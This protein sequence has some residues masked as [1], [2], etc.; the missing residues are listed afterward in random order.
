[1]SPAQEIYQ[2]VQGGAAAQ[3]TTMPDIPLPANILP[4]QIR[5]CFHLGQF[6]LALVLQPS[7]NIWL[8]LPA[9][10]VPS[11]QGLLLT[12]EGA[13]SWTPFLQIQ[14][15]APTDK[16]NPYYLWTDQ[17][18]LYLTIVDQGGAG[19]G[20]GVMKLLALAPEGTWSLVGCYYFGTYSDPEQDG[21]YFQFSQRLDLQRALP[22]EDCANL[23]LLE[24]TRSQP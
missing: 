22:A 2:L 13:S 14:D 19:S 15:H 5:K 20:E 7:M 3:E 4:A 18:K 9:G 8:D 12:S 1:V 6:Y 23:E 16:N 11:F 17:G 24:P 10:V 21:D